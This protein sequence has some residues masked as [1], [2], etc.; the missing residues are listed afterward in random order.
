MKKMKKILLFS[1]IIVVMFSLSGCLLL[2][3]NTSDNKD[4]YVINNHKGNYLWSGAMN[5]AWNDLNQ[6]ILGEK[7]KLKT[8]DKEALNTTE[9]FNNS[10]FTKKDLNKDSYY[11]KSG[12]GQNTVKKINKEMKEKFPNDNFGHLDKNLNPKEIV[13]YAY[14]AKEVEYPTEFSKKNCRFKK[15]EVKGFYAKNHEQRENINI[16]K[17]WND[18]NF[19]IGLKLKNKE[20][21]LFL[22]KGF[23]MDDPQGVVTEIN[24]HNNNSNDMAEE[25]K[26]E[27]PELHLDYKK[28][29]KNITGEQLANEGF[30]E[31]Y[32]SDMREKVEFNMDNKGA[33]VK[34]LG[35]IGG[36]Y[37]ATKEKA[38][39]KL[40]ILNKPFWVVMKMK[41]SDNPYFILGVNNTNIMNKT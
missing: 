34:S 29:Y 31:Y 35:F 8:N 9:K 25:D 11:I 3:N 2:K 32:I 10:T 7:L 17:Y 41:K 39:P 4:Y 12:Y 1:L 15:E 37:G 38:N 18:D 23:N 6:N 21:E 14:F 30:E 22:A 40:L 36:S 13:A 28:E 26:F 24:K 20:D 5:L 27:M 19:I 16:L 33:K